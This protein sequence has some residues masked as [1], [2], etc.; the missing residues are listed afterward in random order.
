MEI[1][2]AQ[3]LYSFIDAALQTTLSS[4]MQNAM[5][6]L[7]GLIGT[8]WMVSFT[9]RSIRWLYMGMTE[10]FQDVVYEIFKVAF[11][12]GMAFNLNW[13]ISTI[14]PFVTDAPA[15][16][17]GVLSGQSG[18]QINQID[19]MMTSYINSLLEMMKML[20]ISIWDTDFEVLMLAVVSVSIYLLGGIPFLL[21]CV[22]TLLVIKAA[23]TLL[24][25]LG[26]LFIAFALFDATRQ[27]FWGWVSQIAGFMLTQVLFS[28]V[29]ALEIGF[30]NKMIITDGQINTSLPGVFSMFI[31]F[32]VFLALAVELPNYAASIMGGSPTSGG[33]LRGAL[34]KTSGFSAAQKLAGL[35]RKKMPSR[36]R[37]G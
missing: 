35:M 20:K 31:F 23:T 36:N 13:Y 37:I 16:L 3:T 22:S 28:V 5:L 4:G 1:N 25:A 30:V 7:G 6:V 8:F 21:A 12:A 17:G 24:L 10:T 26:P 34:A 19:S 18:T 11:I 27:W 9:L 33:G 29:L 32:A 14:V 15:W 2:V